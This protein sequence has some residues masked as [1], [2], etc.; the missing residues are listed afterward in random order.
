MEVLEARCDVWGVEACLVSGEGFYISEV[1]EKLASID[2][3][4]DEIKIPSVL[5]KAFEVDDEG[6]GDLWVHEVLVV[7]VINLLG[8][9]DLVL[10]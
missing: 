8:L 3:F 4:K 9:H 5:G 6:M 7:D 1:S 10:V 2:E